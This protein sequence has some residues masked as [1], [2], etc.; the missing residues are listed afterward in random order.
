VNAGESETVRISMQKPQGTSEQMLGEQRWPVG[1]KSFQEPINFFFF[2]FPLAGLGERRS[3]WLLGTDLVGGKQST[4][5]WYQGL[6][7][8]AADGIFFLF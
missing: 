7:T 3:S 4:P 1:Y 5:G 2:L 8:P 6:L